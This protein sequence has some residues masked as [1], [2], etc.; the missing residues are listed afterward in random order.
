MGHGEAGW[1]KELL[2]NADADQN[3]S[4]SFDEFKDFLHPEDRDNKRVQEWLLKKKIQHMDL[5]GDGKL[6]FIE[7]YEQ[8]YDVFKNYVGFETAGADLPTAE[9]KFAELDVN[10]DRFLAVEELKPIFHYLHPGELSHAKYYTGYLI[11]QFSCYSF[12]VA[13]ALP[14]LMIAKMGTYHLMRCSITSMFSIAQSIMKAM[15]I[16]T[17]TTTMNCEVGSPIFLFSAL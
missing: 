13:S 16:M 5:D 2:E 8:A 6:N 12:T 10:K 9:G 1:W 17:K 11:Q 3:G 14:K 7:F 4:L 15:E